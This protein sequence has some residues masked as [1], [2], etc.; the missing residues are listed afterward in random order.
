MPVRQF[1]CLNI[2]V[3][4]ENQG[5]GIPMPDLSGLGLFAGGQVDFA[6]ELVCRQVNL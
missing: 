3:N 2:V 4:E 1:L 6:K 5:C